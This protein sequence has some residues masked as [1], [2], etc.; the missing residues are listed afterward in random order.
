MDITT[1]TSKR[2]L[3]SGASGLIILILL[4]T[5]P[6]YAPGY[7]VVLFSSI[8]MY[9][10]LAVSWLMFSGPT[11]YI[12]LA[13]AAFFGV[14]IYASAIIGKAL[15]FPILVGIGG[16][17]S[18]CLAVLV[19]ALTLRL[20][21]IYFAI[22]TF[23]LVML[24]AY[25]LLFWELHVTGTRGRFVMVMGYNTIYYYMLGICLLLLLTAYLMQRSRFGLALQGIGQ[26]EEAAAHSGVNVTVVKVTTFAI[27]AFF[28]G[29][30][31]AVMATKW[32]YIDP[33][34][35]FNAN[36]SFMPVVMAMFGGMGQLYGPIIGA[37]ILTYLEEILI[38]K[39]PEIYMLIFGAILVI[40]ILYLPDGLVGMIQK[41]WR[42]ISGRKHAVT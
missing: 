13:P 22:F 39:F 41:I 21:G 33:F 7:T 18:F 15:P 14:G 3:V 17:L 12:S 20:R 24:M 16:L 10:V 23:G 34:I 42:Q 19:G 38:T 2:F 32:T 29:A 5:V 35:A 36:F 27:S 8:L 6:L 9:I 40:A 30:A 1:L 31:G 26:Q 11:G 4:A 37:V 25:S 28:M